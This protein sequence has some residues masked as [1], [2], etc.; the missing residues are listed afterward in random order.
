MSNVEQEE[1]KKVVDELAREIHGIYGQHATEVGLKTPKW[2]ELSDSA[3]RVSRDMAKFMLLKM[4]EV[5]SSRS[6]KTEVVE[7][8]SLAIPLP[9][10]WTKQEAVEFVKEVKPEI[11][12][13]I[14]KF[15]VSREESPVAKGIDEAI[16]KVTE[17]IALGLIADDESVMEKLKSI[18]DAEID[19]LL[20]Q[21]E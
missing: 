8:P 12:G 15:T 5:E 18:V 16:A 9:K 13:L 17:R 7:K 10:S 20:N 1:A 4:A 11:E 2:E 21:E 6:K 3:K 19:R 14:D